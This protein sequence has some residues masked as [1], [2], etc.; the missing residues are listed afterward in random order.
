MNFIVIQILIEEMR[1]VYKE[2]VVMKRKI[3]S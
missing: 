1:N 2:I 3:H